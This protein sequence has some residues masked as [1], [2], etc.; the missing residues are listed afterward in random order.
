MFESAYAPSYKAAGIHAA[1][2]FLMAKTKQPLI[3]QCPIS[4]LSFD[5][6]YPITTIHTL[7]AAA[8]WKP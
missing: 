8:E 4:E 1:V 3:L 2:W 6:C 7:S 5:E